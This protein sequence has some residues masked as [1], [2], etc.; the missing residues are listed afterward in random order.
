MKQV[1]ILLA[2]YN[3]KKYLAQQLDSI[4]SQTHT[5][6]RL[7]IRDDDSSDSTLDII[8]SYTEKYP[9]QIILI[10]DEEKNLG[11]YQNFARLLQEAS[12]NYIMFCD[13]DDVWLETKVADTLRAMVDNERGVTP[14][15]VHT[16]LEVVDATLQRLHP[17]FVKKMRI[18]V[19]RDRF[20][21]LLM[22][23]IATG[24]T[25]MIN[26]PLLDL[27]LPLPENGVIHDWW[28][29]LVASI[30][31]HIIYLDKAT[32]LY[33]QHGN[34]TI[35]ASQESGWEY[36][37]KE[38]DFKT[39]E[40]IHTVQQAILLEERYKEMLPLE[41]KRVLDIFTN[42]LENRGYKR[43]LLQLRYGFLYHNV[44]KNLG[45]MVKS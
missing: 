7:L 28:I 9:S 21:Q 25:M 17:S 10:E 2:T 1:D 6:W 40:L 15:L 34:N 11:A 19:K 35:G 13:Q 38:F 23:N 32:I 5:A 36:I 3:G 16:D 31:G 4:L 24:C 43:K 44:F 37:Q 27:I 41:K 33:R 12:N 14:L 8:Q 45:L 20:N 18:N 29:V 30:Y 22:R 39:I 26:R 42:L